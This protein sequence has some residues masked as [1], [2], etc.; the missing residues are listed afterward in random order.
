MII[1]GEKE[2]NSQSVS[3]RDRK[4]G[5]IGIVELESFINMIEVKVKNKENDSIEA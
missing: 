1:F 5:D 3:V 4:K 2:E